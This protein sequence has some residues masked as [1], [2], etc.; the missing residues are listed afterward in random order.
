MESEIIAFLKA[1]D[2]PAI[3]DRGNREVTAVRSDSD[4]LRVDLVLD[5]L[6]TERLPEILKVPL[7]S[8][9][10]ISCVDLGMV[11][12]EDRYWLVD[13][14]DGTRE[15]RNGIP[16]YA[17][18][19]ALVEHGVPVLGVIFNPERGE[20]F[21]SGESCFTPDA[22]IADAITQGAYLLSRSEH[23]RGLHQ[24]EGALAVKH[25]PLGSVAYKLGIVAA[26]D[27]RIGLVSYQPKNIWDVGAG[28]ALLRN[29]CGTELKTL[30]GE[31]VSFRLPPARIPSLH[32][33][34]KR[35]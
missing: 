21:T 31:S 5:S 32:V 19:I 7:V 28:A 25:V 15:Y 22:R 35:A 24:K 11:A 23:A 9:E 10:T 3:L 2:W 34:P 4:Q 13:P 26:L 18:S 6:L 27:R 20:Y 14:L 29:R 16:E 12:R 8:E 1:Q 33:P 30:A 17:V